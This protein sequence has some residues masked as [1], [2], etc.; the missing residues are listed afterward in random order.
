MFRGQFEH[1]ID[2]KGRLSVPARFREVLAAKSPER[3]IATSWDGCV[4]AYCVPDFEEIEKK[5][6]AAPQNG[7][8][9]MFIR[10]FIGGAHECEIDP[11]GRILV[12]PSLRKYAGL[13]K[14]VVLVGAA[15]RFEIW[16]AD[17]WK[18]ETEKYEAVLAS[19][20]DFV[21]EI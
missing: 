21:P 15:K 8:N 5:H 19:N 10:L 7:E 9:K 18:Q 13:E 14:D 11:S 17:R 2:A 4:L 6:S 3:L 12:P 16:S 1:T 20:K